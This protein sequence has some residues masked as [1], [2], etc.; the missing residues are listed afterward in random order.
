MCFDETS[1]F[2]VKLLPNQVELVDSLTTN[3]QSL[4]GCGVSETL[5]DNS[6][7]QIDENE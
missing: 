1:T 7:E 3:L 5:K 2:R 4:L 6:N